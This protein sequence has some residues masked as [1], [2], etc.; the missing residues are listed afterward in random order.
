MRMGDIM[1]SYDRYIATLK[2]RAR[3]ELCF[4]GALNFIIL[5]NVVTSVTDLEFVVQS[6]I[7]IVCLILM[8]QEVRIYRDLFN[9]DPPP[10]QGELDL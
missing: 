9:P 7:F 5:C 4:I 1:T 2:K 3:A 6:L 10:V 8:W